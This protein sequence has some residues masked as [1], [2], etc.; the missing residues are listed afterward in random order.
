MI[1]SSLDTLGPW[2][3][4]VV[5][6][7]L[8]ALELLAPGVFFL[9]LGLAA[10]LTGILDLIFDLSWQASALV[11]AV[12]AAAAVGLGRWLTRRADEAEPDQPFLNRRG[13]A[14]VGLTVPLDQA[15]VGGEGRIRV[16]DSVWRVTGPDLPA[17]AAVRV[18]RM[19]GATLVVEGV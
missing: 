14:L 2:A 3:W 18:A 10:I 11:F 12:F 16:G 9:W 8:A 7:V 17:G 15:I 13:E 5:G 4:I 1:A 6:I 19:E